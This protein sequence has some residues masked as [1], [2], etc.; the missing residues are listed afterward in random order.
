M[1]QVVILL[2]T[3]LSIII[4]LIL[5][6]IYLNNFSDERFLFLDGLRNREVRGRIKKKK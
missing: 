6:F 2:R 3:G 1:T 4:Y 5:I